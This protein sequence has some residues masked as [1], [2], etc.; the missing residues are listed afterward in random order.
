MAIPQLTSPLLID[1]LPVCQLYCLAQKPGWEL[2]R[3]IPDLRIWKNLRLSMPL[4][5]ALQE[6]SVPAFS[7]S[8]GMSKQGM[9]YSLLTRIIQAGASSIFRHLLGKGEIPSSIITLPELCCMLTVQQPDNITVP[10]LSALEEFH[11]GLLKGTQ[12]AL[13]R[14]LL[15]YSVHNYQTGWFHPKCQLT[16]FLLEKG[17][18]PQNTNPLGL[19]WQE[20][21]DS[22]SVGNKQLLMNQRYYFQAFCNPGSQLRVKQPLSD[23]A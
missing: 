8:C 7:I 5:Q 1:Y 2:L 12:D 23:I 17:C 18:D 15:W 4:Q 10:F 13:G 20:F 22:L 19:S 11:P 14:N 16:H 21:T 6:D 9:S 3:H